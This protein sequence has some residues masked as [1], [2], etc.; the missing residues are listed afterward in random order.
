MPRALKIRK[1]PVTM[2]LPVDLLDLLDEFCRDR[3]IPKVTVCE[4]AL[5]RFLTVEGGGEG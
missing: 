4:L 2:A 5:R 3:R 1:A